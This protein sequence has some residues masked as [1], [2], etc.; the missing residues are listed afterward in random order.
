[1]KYDLS[2]VGIYPN[3]QYE[4]IY[5]TINSDNEK[6]SAAFAFIY[7]GENR[8]KCRIF[9][10]SQTLKN[11][12]ETKQYVVNITQN[13]IIFTKSTI[14]K[15]DSS[16]FTDDEEIAILKDAGSYMVIDVE[17]I[18]TNSNHDFPIKNNTKL[19]FIEG[20]IKDFVV[21]DN[22]I[23]AFNRGFSSIIESLVNFSRYKI[24]NDEKRQYYF[25]RLMENKRIIDKVSDENTQKA[26]DLLVDEYRKN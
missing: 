11:I 3:L 23:K 14:D 7:L 24:V 5:T 1:M 4:C 16:F 18:E 8:V 10:G 22:S 26:M 21:N 19:F 6:N 12:Q 13:P 2:S 17:K 20:I 15:L 9:E 25:N